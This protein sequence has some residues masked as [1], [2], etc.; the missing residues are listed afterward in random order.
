MLTRILHN[1]PPLCK[2]FDQVASV[3][4][5]VEGRQTF[6]CPQR[7]H[8]INVADALLVC[9]EH[10]TLAALQRQFVEAVDVSNWADCFRISPWSATTLRN[11][12]G[13]FLIRQ[14]VIVAESSSGPVPILVSID[15]SVGE[16]DKATRHI[17]PVGW[18]YDHLESTKNNP[19]YK[20]GLAYLACTVRVGKIEFT[21]DLQIYLRQ[22]T[23]RRINRR[24]PKDQ[25]IHF[26]SKTHLA[27]RILTRLQPL[28]PK[29]WPVYVLFDAWYT[30]ARLLKFIRRQDWHVIC[31]VKSNRK[32]NQKRIDQ[33]ACTLKHQRYMTVRTTAADGKRTTYWVRSLQGRLEDVPFDVCV[34]V[35]RR[36]PREKS[37][38]YFLS[39]DLTL[40]VQQGFQWY[41]QRWSCEVA[42]FYLKTRLGLTDFRVQSYEAVDKWVAVV[43]LS[44][45]YLQWRLAQ[46]RSTLLKTPADL[47]RRHQDEHARVWLIGACQLALEEGNVEPVLQRFLREEA[48]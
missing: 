31:A 35:S 46:E 30:S 41:T 33:Q 18:H 32:L 44:W 45:A 48:L 36:H 29:G 27:H 37:P 21:F 9:Q 40:E 3:C 39:T 20:N 38:A 15:D 12:L 14:A 47:I 2:F 6:F 19:R 28:L 34:W 17:E 26:I 22:R 5:S 8:I 13:A 1:S 4:P 24:R 43:Q 11:G 10:K 23:V 16:K 42:N 25:H 7:R